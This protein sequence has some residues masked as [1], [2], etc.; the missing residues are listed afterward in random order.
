M[1]AIFAVAL[2]ARAIF[3]L[4]APANPLHGTPFALADSLLYDAHA[5]E[6]LSGRWI[7]A[8]PYF[9]APLYGH[10]LAAIYAVLAPAGWAVHATQAILGAATCVL[11]ADVARRLFSARVGV[12][13]G[14]AC[15]LYAPHVYYTGH[16][17]PT[18]SVVFLNFLFV[19]ILL[20]SEEDLRIRSAAAAGGV[21][22]L[23]ILAKSNAIL[24]LPATLAG[25]LCWNRSGAPRR[26]LQWVATLALCAVIVT[27]PAAVHN[28]LASGELVPVT[29][30]T[31]RNLWKGNGPIANGTHP[32]GHWEGDRSG[33][34]R[35]LRGEV[36]AQTAVAESAS[37]TARTLGYV[38]EHP[39][40][41]LQLL[42][43]KLV[44]L[45]NAVE[46]GVRDQYYFAKDHVPLLRGPLFGFGLIAPLGLA[47]LVATRRR[48]TREWPLLA[49]LAC[50]VVS[51]VA[52]F[53]LARY[54]LVAAFALVVY[55][56]AL[57][58][59]FWEDARARRWRALA[60]S[61][62][63]AVVAAVI[64]N[65]PLAEF[66]PERGYALQW[67]RIGD[68]RRLDGDAAEAIQAYQRAM[69]GD[70]QDLDPEIKRGET[71]LRMARAHAEL[72]D[73][74]AARALVAEVLDA[75]L[76]EAPRAERLRRDATAFG[77]DLSGR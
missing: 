22:G 19:W 44:L 12:I 30:S 40:R 57:V 63:V 65:W 3:L 59:A 69:V 76:G 68:Q 10:L 1:A 32:L 48:L 2:G 20:R 35:R 43:K 71:R 42:V 18:V 15:A 37:Y 38:A 39:G 31:G 24:L 49:L 6:L 26:R 64:V 25:V 21:L 55:A 72:G 52:V 5:R 67:E 46:L 7:G 56:S 58:A 53:V 73:A 23:A 14:V 41:G 77:A 27:A 17:L 29:T 33:V 50:Q 9:L 28:F 13:A 16:L 62:A 74:A 47:G 11:V 34:G 60:S 61:L 45:L 36:D 66:P 51:F 8:A 54:R 70:W 4:Q 75:P